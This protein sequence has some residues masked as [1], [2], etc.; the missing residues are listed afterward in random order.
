M[1]PI[2][3]FM[4]IPFLCVGRFASPRKKEVSIDWRPM[5]YADSAKLH[6]SDA[7][8]YGRAGAIPSFAGRG[9]RAA[10][11]REGLGLG[12]ARP[13]TGQGRALPISKRAPDRAM[14]NVFDEPS[15]NV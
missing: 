10:T 15:A 2:I 5:P 12:G 1:I 11:R 7:E 9:L 4:T 8:S 3:R 6:N 14:R 13:W